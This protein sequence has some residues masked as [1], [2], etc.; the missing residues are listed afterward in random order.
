MP[1]LTFEEWKEKI[2]T[3]VKSKIHINID[4]LPD[5]TYRDWYDNNNLQ[6]EEISFIILGEYYKSIDKQAQFCKSLL[7]KSNECLA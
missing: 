5:M 1:E 2:N 3:L 7:E 4:E 6:P